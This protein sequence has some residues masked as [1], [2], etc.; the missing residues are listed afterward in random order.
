[1]SKNGISVKCSRAQIPAFPRPGYKILLRSLISEP[2][3]SFNNGEIQDFPAG[4]LQPG[5]GQHW[6]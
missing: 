1:M 3:F 6:I 4:E 5:T 2:V